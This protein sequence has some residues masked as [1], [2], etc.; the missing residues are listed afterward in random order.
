[1]E[2]K[3]MYVQYA[4]SKLHPIQ[5][6]IENALNNPIIEKDYNLQLF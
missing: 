6:A 4:E 1:M 5:G 3:I 2:E